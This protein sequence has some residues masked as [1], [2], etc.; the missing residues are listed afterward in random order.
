MYMV[1]LYCT[2]I[3]IQRKLKVFFRIVALCR[4]DMTD[5]K[6]GFWPLVA[7]LRGAPI[8]VQLWGPIQNP[9]S[10]CAECG[11][12]SRPASLHHL[13]LANIILYCV[14]LY[15]NWKSGSTPA[16]DR[17]RIGMTEFR[18]PCLAAAYPPQKRGA[19]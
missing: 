3:Q 5:P 12:S 10:G 6:V 7:Y 4:A 14:V 9:V 17:T 16:Q 11:A 13:V 1:M 15:S 2:V 8:W 18:K 19:P